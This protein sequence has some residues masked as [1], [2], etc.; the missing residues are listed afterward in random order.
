MWD[1]QLRKVSTMVYDILFCVAI[2]QAQGHGIGNI[3][4]GANFWDQ[5][6]MYIFHENKI[7]KNVYICTQAV[8]YKREILN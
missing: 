8:V 6:W 7:K 3:F 2:A 5:K 1:W 4:I